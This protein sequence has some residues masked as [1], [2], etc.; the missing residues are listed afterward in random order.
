ML[1]KFERASLQFYKMAVD[2]VVCLVVTAIILNS[3]CFITLVS[4]KSE[5]NQIL[6]VPS[7]AHCSNATYI[8]CLTLVQCLKRINNCFLSNTVVT[9]LS[10]DHHTEDEIGFKIIRNKRNLVLRSEFVPSSIPSSKI[11][12]SKGFSLAFVNIHR[13]FIFG[14]GFYNCG[15]RILNELREEAITIQTKTY[16][17]FFEGTK[18]ALFVVNVY[19]MQFNHVH[20]NLDCSY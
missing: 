18:M 16:F 14:L 12:C 1:D 5:Q 8:P 15:S 3:Q 9:F 20:I 11:Y 7:E 13:F 10:G 2:N 4:T 6:L 17:E 19:N